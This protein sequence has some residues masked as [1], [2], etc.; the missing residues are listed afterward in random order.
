MGFSLGS[1][2]YASLLLVNAL[3]ILHEERFLQRIGWGVTHNA[4]PS[5]KDQ[6][7]NLLKSVRMLLRIPL[8]VVN[9]IVMAYAMILGA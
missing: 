5:V 4:D 3:A 9:I 1:L 8:I 7:S 6:I 2:L